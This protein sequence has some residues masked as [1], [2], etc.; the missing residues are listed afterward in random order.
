MKNVL[1][2]ANSGI[3]ANAKKNCSLKV[4]IFQTD[5][6]EDDLLKMMNMIVLHC[7]AVSDNVKIYM[8][9]EFCAESSC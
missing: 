9:K 2:M 3:R 6:N 5:T 8:W 1:C 4:P 7:V